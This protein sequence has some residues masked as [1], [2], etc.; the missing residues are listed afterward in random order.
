MFNSTTEATRREAETKVDKQKRYGEILAMLSKW[1]DL[2]AKECAYLMWQQ[3]FI[4]TAERNFTAPRLTE[5]MQS[6]KVEVTRKKKCMWTGRNV[7]V[8]GLSGD[9]CN[10]EI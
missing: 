2:T 9:Y 1:G 3:G 6:G 5:L 8:Y 7:A 10:E 4:P